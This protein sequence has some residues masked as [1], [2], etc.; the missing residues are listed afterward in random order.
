MNYCSIEDAWGKVNYMSNQYKGYMNNET[1][2]YPSNSHQN[3]ENFDT[4]SQ[5]INQ[6]NLYDTP[7]T[8]LDRRTNIPSNDSHI[9]YN[10][11]DF[12]KHI[13]SCRKCYNRTKNY[14]KPKIMESVH[15][16]IDNNKDSIVLILIGISILLFFNLLNNLTYNRNI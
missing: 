7:N 13:K 12:V 14:F 3:I 16:L 1:P 5:Q 4:P 15:E 11:D 2:T 9:L 10:C 8:H 6:N